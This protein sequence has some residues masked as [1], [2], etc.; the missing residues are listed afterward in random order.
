ML[1]E[2]GST[3]IGLQ[4]SNLHPQSQLLMRMNESESQIFIV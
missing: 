4:S 1:K 3:V 2:K